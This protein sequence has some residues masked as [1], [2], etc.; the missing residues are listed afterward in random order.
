MGKVSHLHVVNKLLY[1]HLGLMHACYI[2]EA[3]TDTGLAIHNGDLGHL[4]LILLRPVN[5]PDKLVEHN[6]NLNVHTPV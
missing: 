5:A 2:F 4:Q 6:E 1:F 3:H